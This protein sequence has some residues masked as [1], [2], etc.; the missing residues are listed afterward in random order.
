[1]TEI[2]YILSAVP[3]KV[4]RFLLCAAAAQKTLCAAKKLQ[5]DATLNFGDF[6]LFF[7]S[8]KNAASGTQLSYAVQSPEGI[9]SKDLQV[10]LS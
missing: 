4:R 6:W 3:A 7:F 5:S 8:Y 2:E 10:W 1:M 9:N